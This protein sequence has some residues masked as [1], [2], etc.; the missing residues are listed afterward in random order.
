MKWGDRTDVMSKF[1]KR[2]AP[3]V[4]LFW[5]AII[6]LVAFLGEK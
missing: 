3:G 4:V 5:A 1:W 6:I 2:N